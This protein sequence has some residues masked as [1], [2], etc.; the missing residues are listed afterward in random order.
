MNELE[1]WEGAEQNR[2][3]VIKWKSE[4][5][6][7]L[8]KLD[9]YEHPISSSLWTTEGWSELWKLPEMD[10]VQSHYYANAEKDMAEEVI[11]ICSQKRNEY[12]DKLHLFAE[13]GIL[14]GSGTRENDPDGI[15]LHNGNWASLMSGCASVPISWWHESYIDPQGLYKVYKG[16]ANFVAEEKDIAK[17]AWKPL[18]LVSVSYIN[19]PE[20]ITFSDLRF[21]LSG[22][23]WKKLETSSFN[24]GNDGTIENIDRIPSL[25]HGNGHKEL[26][27]PLIFNVNYQ[28]DGKF[29][30]HI[31][32]VGQDGLLKVFIDGVEVASISLPTG[33]GLGL[34]S[35]Y[36]QRWKRWE[37]VYNM[38][39]SIDVPKG[40][41]E[42]RIQNDG[43]DWINIEYIQLVNYLSNIKPNLRIIGMQ[44]QSKALLWLQNKDHTWFNVRNKKVIEQV[45]PSRVILSGF[46]DGEFD[47]EL[48]DTRE[49]KAIKQESCKAEGNKLELDIPEIK[50]DIAIKIKQKGK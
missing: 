5:A 13:Y 14:S 2:S 12:P 9:P 11:K 34:Y 25:L 39:V 20:Q 37:T 19:P 4:M 32:R 41:H 18:E 22:E 29:I 3:A 46:G 40:K 43:V 42:I 47:I 33:E 23:S 30:L 31:G 44:T 50:S 36:V 16:I 6:K 35:E 38:D 8:R 49:G 45:L 17:N 48:W 27:V 28:T 21:T 24:I 15:H 26:Q 10:F 1:G 7:A